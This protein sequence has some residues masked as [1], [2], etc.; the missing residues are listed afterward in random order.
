[1]SAEFEARRILEATLG[2]DQCQRLGALPAELHP[3]R[4]LKAALAAAHGPLLFLR[5]DAQLI[6]QCFG[7]FQIASVEALGIFQ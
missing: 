4:V 5:S 3:L 6:E 1:L 7:I 2:T